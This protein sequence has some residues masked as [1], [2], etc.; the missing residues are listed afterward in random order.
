MM[1]ATCT[2]LPSRRAVTTLISTTTLLVV[3]ISAVVCLG[4]FGRHTFRGEIVI[5]SSSSSQTLLRSARSDGSSSS[6]FVF[7]Q[8]FPLEDTWE[9]LFHTEVVVCRRDTFDSDF[10]TTLDDLAKTISTT[11]SDTDAK[12]PFVQ[13]PE[14]QW[15]KQSTAKCVQLGYGGSDC[16]ATC[17]GSPHGQ[18][19]TNYALNSRDAVIGNAMGEKKELFLYGIS[20]DSSKN[21]DKEGGISGIDAYR[22]I[23]P[24]TS[25]ESMKLPTCVSKWTGVDYN[26]IT[27]NCNKFTSAI[28][29]CVYGLSDKKPNL[30]VSDMITVACPME[31]KEDGINVQQCLIPSLRNAADIIIA[32]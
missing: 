17:C 27:N 5:S 24:A 31:T 30:G 4:V 28:L 11:P 25:K 9:M 13:V 26:P 32:E 19:N 1:A 14:G 29:K 15:V 3:I 22:A 20:G 12:A 2:F 6:Y 18:E 23:C 10:L 7:L 8:K 16:S 21:S